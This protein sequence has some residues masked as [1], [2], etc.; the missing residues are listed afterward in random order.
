MTKTE[1]EA[2]LEAKKVPKQIYSLEG[3][4]DGEC[5]CIVKDGDSWSVIYMERGR[6]SDIATG[7]S[8]DEAY[9]AIYHEFR[10]MYGWT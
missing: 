4:R 6:T 5:Y 7:L 10:S 9:D 2:S 1:L 8:E 3:L